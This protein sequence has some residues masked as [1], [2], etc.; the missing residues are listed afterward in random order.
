MP[1]AVQAIGP[2][3]MA[4]GFSLAGVPVIEVSSTEEGVA[5]LAEALARD[6]IG[7]LL[8]DESIVKALPEDL[9]RR[10]VRK[11]IPVVVPVPRPK[12]ENREEDIASYIL[13]L[14]QRAIGYR[15]R[16]K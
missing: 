15:M 14:L 5:R 10:T 3:D 7:V 8:A 4:A 16:L 1:Y 6:D 11:P 9:R 12:W 2:G 13:D